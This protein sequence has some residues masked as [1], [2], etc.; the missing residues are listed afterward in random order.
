MYY[1]GLRNRYQGPES[2]GKRIYC[3]S[4]PCSSQYD[5]EPFGHINRERLH[6][7]CGPGAMMEA[8]QRLVI[9]LDYMTLVQLHMNSSCEK[10]DFLL[11]IHQGDSAG[12]WHIF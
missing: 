1:S 7:R 11:S 5:S 8:G 3:S 12:I 10:P 6:H 9:L 2:K 4:N